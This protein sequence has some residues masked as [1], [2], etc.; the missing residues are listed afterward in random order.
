V[1]GNLTS[2]VEDLA[3]AGQLDD[4]RPLVRQL[5]TMIQELIQQVDGLSLDTLQRQVASPP[6]RC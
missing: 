3:A 5:E 4:I 2:D 1:A 6:S